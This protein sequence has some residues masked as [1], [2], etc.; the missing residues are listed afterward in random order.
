MGTK[1]FYTCVI[2]DLFS[3]MVVAYGI[4][5]K[6]ST[7]LVSA[8][9]RKAYTER[10]PKDGLVFHSDRGVQ[11]ASHSFQKLLSEHNVTQSFSASGKPHDNAVEEAFFASLKREA[12]YRHDYTSEKA[13]CN[14]VE[15]YI[16]FYNCRRPHFT[17]NYKTPAQ[18]EAN[19]QK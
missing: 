10:T 5:K 7:Q 16:D 8:T 19:P 14:G 15:K 11:Y 13:F 1:Y 6:N 18:F 17:L 4:S 2:I 9:F 3:R 12:I